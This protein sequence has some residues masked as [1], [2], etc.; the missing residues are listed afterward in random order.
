MRTFVLFLITLLFSG[1][2]LL[3]QTDDDYIEIGR[4]VLKTEKKA[5]I[6][7]AM[8]LTDAESGPFWELYNEYNDKMY[9]VQNKRV[10]II[11]DYANNYASMTD[12]KADELWQGAFSYQQE[13]LKLEKTYYKKFKKIL[14]AAKAARYFQAEHKIEALI[15]AKLALEIPLVET[16]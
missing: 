13:L 16:N 6:A 2:H 5:A 9:Q 10:A 14:P 3:A 7:Q 8:Q 4:S 12:A 15:N 1:V 11:K